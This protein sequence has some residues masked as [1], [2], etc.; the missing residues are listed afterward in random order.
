MPGTILPR[1]IT[2]VL[3]SSKQSIINQPGERDN[4]VFFSH[5]YY[6]FHIVLHTPLSLCTSGDRLYDYS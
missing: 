2:L 5:I 6:D 4:K 3:A 1:H